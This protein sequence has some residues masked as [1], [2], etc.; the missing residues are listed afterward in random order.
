MGKRGPRPKPTNLRLIEGNPGRQ[1][2]NTS[3]PVPS[4][5]PD[6]PEYMCDDAKTKWR[7]IMESVPPGMITSADSP[8]LEA[9]CEAWATHK[10]ATELM[11]ATPPDLFGDNL[12][13]KGKASAYL[14]IRS[15]AAKTMA[16]LATRLGLSPAARSGLKLNTPKGNSK[17]S[18]LIG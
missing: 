7:D 12:T 4:G 5:T 13:S 6:C 14:K 9:Y 17:W 3:E 1:P 15:D 16:S 2:I 18:G 8:L 11:K 10:R